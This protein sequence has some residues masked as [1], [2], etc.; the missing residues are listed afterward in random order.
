MSMD[1]SNVGIGNYK[2]VMLCNRPFGG[3]AVAPAAAK[4]D[5]RSFHAGVV[6]T[7]VGQNVSISSLVKVS[8]ICFVV[9]FLLFFGCC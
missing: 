8:L 3:S 1:R 9:S 7:D 2:G 6:P 5:T 4:P